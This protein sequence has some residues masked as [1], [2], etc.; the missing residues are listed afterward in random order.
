MKFTSVITL[1]ILTAHLARADDMIEQ[2]IAAAKHAMENDLWDVATSKLKS[3]A[4][5]ANLTPD[6]RAEILIMLAESF[7]R[8]NQPTKALTLLD[9][10]TVANLPETPFWR[11]LALAGSGRFNDAAESLAIIAEQPT[12]PF[13]REA[14]LT[15]ASLYLSLGQP[16]KSLKILNLL[17]SSPKS[18]DRIDAAFHQ[19]EILIDLGE[20]DQARSHFIKAKEIPKNLIPAAKFLDATLTLKAGDAAAAEII[21]ADLIAKPDGQSTARYGLAAIGKADAIAAQNKPAIATQFLLTF[22]QDHPQ[23]TA[24]NPIF[25]RIIDWLPEQIITTDHPTLVQ[26]NE[27]IPATLPPSTGL[28][29]TEAATAAAA[30]PIESSEL[31]DLVVFSM[32]ARAIGL[33]RINNPAAKI[34]ARLLMQRI[35]L[36]APHHF[37]AP[38]SLFEL[39][40]WQLEANEPEQAFALL[41][42]LRQTTKSALIKGEATFLDAKIA[43]EQGEKDLAISLFDEAANLLSQENRNNSLINSAL[44]RLNESNRESLTIKHEDPAIE[45]KLNI[46][47][48]LE[49]ALTLRDPEKA[50]LSLDTFLTE[51]P[52]HTR[53]IEARIAIIEAAIN[54]TPPD[55][56]LARAQ[57][58]IIK[59]TEITLTEEKKSHIAIT[60]LRLLDALNQPEQTIA[61][62]N[63][64]VE[65]FPGTPQEA[66]ALMILGKS[67]FRSKSY[68][69]ARIVFEKIAKSKLGTQRS[70]AAFLLAAR[71]AALGATTQSREEA[72]KLFDQAIAIDGP[73]RSMAILEKARLNIDLNQIDL[74][75]KSL[76][77]AYQKV[78]PDDPSR[79]PTG[80]LLSEA[81]YARGDT[82]PENLLK[83]LEIYNQLVEISVNKPAQ[84]FHIQYLRGLT[85]EKLPDPDNPGQTRLGDALAAYFSVLDRPVDPAPPEWEWFER[86]GFRALTIL[87]N[88]ERWPAA[89]SIAEKIASFGGP[90]TKDAADRARQLRLKH[91]IWED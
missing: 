65:K 77:D 62:A 82:N 10:P 46:E 80:L 1:V 38:K 5:Q 75:I 17:D 74:A 66:E 8:S 24:L 18:S 47:L 16:D 86:S 4:E 53:A 91:M 64:I 9:Q 34:E 50:K 56:S 88:T 83:A 68:N 48:N 13:I 85:L 14:A 36:L 42:S 51:H 28:I 27:W 37:L 69:Q 23:T 7:I 71:S 52:N 63:H 30:L 79:L 29:N 11:G 61:L 6:A 20:Y 32:H 25:H 67:L 90:R 72:L 43:F 35:L 33:H 45:E 89:I 87:E 41:D 3:A 40:K 2:S 54:S 15:S 60:E 49:K 19:A 57:L 21:F 76:T 22:I 44:I 58:D 73:L 55:L 39:A 26:L 70:Q 81:I 78:S 12:H 31:D 84:Y 59:S